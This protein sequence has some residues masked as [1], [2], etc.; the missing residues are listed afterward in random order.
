MTSIQLAI[1]RP[2]SKASVRTT[3]YLEPTH[4]DFS[5]YLEPKINRIL[6]KEKFNDSK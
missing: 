6:V 2:K 1:S 5:W 4:A 3:V